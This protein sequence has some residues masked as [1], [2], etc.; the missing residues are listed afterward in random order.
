MTR[1]KNPL[2]EHLAALVREGRLTRGGAK[3]AAQ[4]GRTQAAWVARRDREA[5]ERQAAWKARQ[6]ETA[7]MADT[8]ARFVEAHIPAFGD[9]VIHQGYPLRDAV[10]KVQE[11]TGCDLDCGHQPISP[12]TVA[13]LL[14]LA[15]AEATATRNGRPSA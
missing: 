6:E 12:A 15:N 13:A 4:A 10:A 11:L 5:A 8:W 1:P 7:R 3:A 2:P 14:E 9:L